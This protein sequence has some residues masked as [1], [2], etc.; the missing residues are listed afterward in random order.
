MHPALG[1]K[2]RVDPLILLFFARVEIPEVKFGCDTCQIV[3]SQYAARYPCPQPSSS[4]G[5]S[6]S[7]IKEP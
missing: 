3:G 7:Q 5:V 6:R 2:S 4:I 1:F